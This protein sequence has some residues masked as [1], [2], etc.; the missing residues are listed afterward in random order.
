MRANVY[1]WLRPETYTQ[2]ENSK[3]H[4]LSGVKQHITS[5]SHPKVIA[6]RKT[7]RSRTLL[8]LSMREQHNTRIS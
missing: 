1:D 2:Q 8:R 6:K 4:R 5:A 7:K 3:L